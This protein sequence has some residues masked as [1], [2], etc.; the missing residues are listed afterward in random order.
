MSEVVPLPSF[1]EVFFD[2]RGQERV[3]RVTWHEGTLVLSLWRGEMCTASFRMPFQ[4]VERLLDTLEE[5]FAEAGGQVAEGAEHPEEAPQPPQPQGDYPEYP[6]TGQYVRPPQEGGTGAHHQPGPYPDAGAYQEQP[7]YPD[8]G[9]YQGGGPYQE[10][11]PY[12]DGGAYQEQGPYQDGGAYQDNRPYPEAAHYDGHSYPESD[13]RM[14]AVP[15]VGPND[16]LV[17]RG[18][19]PTSDKLVA[20]GPVP[21]PPAPYGPQGDQ[22]GQPDQY[23]RQP[24]QY[25]PFPGPAGQHG[26]P[27]P[28]GGPP[29]Q[30]GP[31]G[32]HGAHGQPGQPG[33]PPMESTDPY[34][35]P[36]L[37]QPGGYG[38]QP[39]A[40]D[41][42]D[43]LGLGQVGNRQSRQPAPDYPPSD[44]QPAPE[45]AGPPD[46][47]QPPGGPYQQQADPLAPR[48][49]TPENMY[50]TGERLRRPDEP[51]PPLGDERDPRER[52]REW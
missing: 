29:G 23:G 49:Y 12:Q 32:Q 11:G 24:E 39:P 4:D 30:P 17:A 35:M 37:E 44:Y 13:P 20:S 46:Y 18:N 5:G 22:Y 40:V 42:S 3:L 19:P 33:Q 8:A 2:A 27:G 10:Q 38:K 28:Y 50:S 9:P 7:G 6:G 14:S 25:P 21:P 47:Q 41:P 1:G 26:Q 51:Q 36:P 16:V 48:P 45:Y 15:S 52:R 34:G 43:P 31:H